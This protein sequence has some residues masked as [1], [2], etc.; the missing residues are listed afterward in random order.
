MK[1]EETVKEF[2]DR[3][4]DLVDQIKR[5]ERPDLMKKRPH[6]RSVRVSKNS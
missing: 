3:I 2:G 4:Q 6:P 5:G 1:K